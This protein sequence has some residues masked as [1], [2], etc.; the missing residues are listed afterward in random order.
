[1]IT[2]KQQE[3]F[4]ESMRDFLTTANVQNIDRLVKEVLK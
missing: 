4:V 3:K 2:L 1:M